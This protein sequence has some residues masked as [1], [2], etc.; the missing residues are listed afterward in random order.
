MNHTRRTWATVDLTAAEENINKI[1]SIVGGDCA[2][3]SV[4][5]ADGYGHGAVE[6]SKTIDKNTDYFAVSN[7]DEA[8][9]IR[10]GGIEKPILILGYT[11]PRSMDLIAKYDVTQTVFSYDYGKMLAQAAEDLGKKIKVHIKIDTGMNRLGFS[12]QNEEEKALSTEKIKELYK[13]KNLEFEGIFT[14]FAVADEPEKPFTKIQ[15][16]RFTEFVS[17]LEKE[18][19]KF[20]YRHAANSAAILNFPE[21]KLDMVRPGLILYGITTNRP[22]TVGL[23]PVME[24]K[25]TVSFVHDFRKGDSVSYGQT[26]IAPKDMKI[27]TLPIGYADGLF[28]SLSKSLK[29][30]INGKEAPIIGRICMDQCMVDVSGLDVKTEDEVTVFGGGKSVYELSDAIDTIPYEIICDIGKRVPRVYLK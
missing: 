12:V 29:V 14:H 17:L 30:L 25:T 20:R 16:E 4:V 10:V 5:K 21:M 8:I 22:D 19:I 28:R 23:K 7:I 24:L 15:F 27:A 13:G 18:G 3:M 26:Y 2:I 1:R 11:P 9:Q 6:I